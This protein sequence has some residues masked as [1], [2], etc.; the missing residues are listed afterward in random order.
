[1]H[2]NRFGVIPK[3]HQPGKWCLIVDLSHPSWAS[4]NDRVSRELCLLTYASVN[5]VVWLVLNSGP[6]TI[7]AKLDM[8]SAYRNVPVYP[9]DRPLVGMKWDEKVFVDVALLFGFQ[10]ALKTFNAVTDGLEWVLVHEGVRGV[11]HYLDNFLFVGRPQTPECAMALH[12]AEVVCQC[13]GVPQ[14]LENTEGT[15]PGIWLDVEAME[16]HLP[17]E[18]LTRL[19]ALVSQWQGRKKSQKRELLS[20]IGQ[21]QHVCRVVKPGRSFLNPMIDLSITTRE[22]HHGIRLNCGFRSDLEWWAMFLAPWN[23]VCMLLSIGWAPPDIRL[24]SDAS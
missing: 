21:L 22:L 12:L 13:L 19:A 5:N 20:L 16:L 15:F 17:A 4:V 23:G 1:M 10:S 11:I 6:G 2:T 24:T 8:Q 3:P 9:D 7:L 14:A 18:K